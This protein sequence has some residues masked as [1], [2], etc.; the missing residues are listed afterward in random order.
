[1][2]FD[3]V[4]ASKAAGG[5][6]RP[7]RRQRSALRADCP[8]V[9]GPVARRRTRFASFA[10]YARTT[11]ASQITKRADARG[12]EP[13]APRRCQFAPEPTYP[14]PCGQRSLVFDSREQPSLLHARGQCPDGA[15]WRRGAAQRRGGKSCASAQDRREGPMHGPRSAAHAGP[16]QSPPRSEQRTEPSPQARAATPKP[17][18]GAALGPRADV[19]ET[20]A[21]RTSRLA[22]GAMDLTT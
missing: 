19:D 6:A 13:C 4:R 17:R 7:L 2:T 1:M 5:R 18:Q 12:H 15:H 11:A 9:L 8:A 21:F 3:S 20:A 10:R 22:R 14:Q 16:S